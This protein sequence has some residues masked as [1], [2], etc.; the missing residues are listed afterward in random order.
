[1]PQKMNALELHVVENGAYSSEPFPEV[2]VYID[3]EDLCEILRRIESPLTTNPGNYV[4]LPKCIV[5]G[6]FLGED[7]EW[8]PDHNKTALLECAGCA[9]PGCWTFAARIIV[10]ADSVTWQDFENVHRNQESPGGAW[11]YSALGTLCFDKQQYLS[12]LKKLGV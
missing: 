6:H 5:A 1:M 9:Y 11:D 7:P 2:K 8:G 4:G 12:E 10:D 3:G